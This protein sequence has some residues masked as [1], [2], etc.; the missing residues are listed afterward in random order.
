MFIDCLQALHEIIG[1]KINATIAIFISGHAA[2]FLVATFS[3]NASLLSPMAML[4]HT[5]DAPSSGATVEGHCSVQR[6]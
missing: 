1:E 3:V 2:D 4:A 6:L 5:L